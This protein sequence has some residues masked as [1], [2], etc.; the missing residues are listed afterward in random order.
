[1]RLTPAVRNAVLATAIPLALGSTRLHGQDPTDPPPT[2]PAAEDTLTEAEKEEA[3]RAAA[4]SFEICS[5]LSAWADAYDARRIEG[6]QP[7]DNDAIE[8][9]RAYD[10]VSGGVLA[11]YHPRRN[12][13]TTTRVLQAL[14]DRGEKVDNRATTWG[15]LAAASI[16]YQHPWFDRATERLRDRGHWTLTRLESGAARE[17]LHA[18]GLGKPIPIGLAPDYPH[19][20]TAMRIAAIR[21]L[22]F[23]SDAETPTTLGKALRDPSELVR[24]AAA[25]SLAIKPKAEGLPGLEAALAEEQ[26]PIVAQ[27]LLIAIDK[28]LDAHHETL[29]QERI[30]ECVTIACGIVG[31]VGWRTDLGV[32]ELAH[33]HPS[34]AAIP[35]LIDLLDPD[36]RQTRRT[37]SAIGKLVATG[38]HRAILRDRAF[39]TLRRLTGTL[40]AVDDVDGW[41]KFW[42]TEQDKLVLP[43]RDALDN[44]R[45]A[46]SAGFFGIPIVAGETAFVLDTSNSMGAHIRRPGGERGP[47]RADAAKEQLLAA[48]Q[49]MPKDWK[50]HV[51]LFNERAWSLN[52]RPLH[53]TD[54]TLHGLTR[55]LYRPW[56]GKRTDYLV[57]LD[58]ILGADQQRFGQPT[59]RDIQEILFLSDGEPSG[60]DAPTTDE[61]L[62]RVRK[63]NRYQ[64]VRIN[65]VFFGSRSGGGFMQKLA[66][67]NGGTFVHVE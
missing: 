2:E 31:R 46:T 36:D 11:R 60:I 52:E 9:M 65:T 42:A 25:E 33:A 45:I 48:A 1:M 66:E 64:K 38:N 28:T 13:V 12:Q 16:G 17:V 54:R 19:R 41:R 7:F 27:A 29:G 51:I 47:T 14:L 56:D 50:F 61:V 32:V 5:I 39:Q 4:R 3:E 24:L 37:K 18:F 20:M 55:D 15:I 10:S 49:S 8:E 62:E 21:A 63:L 58:F 34:L 26:H 40:L 67:E 44:S 23:R 35:T 53:P 30:D 57:A 22:G 6:D 59:E 43:S